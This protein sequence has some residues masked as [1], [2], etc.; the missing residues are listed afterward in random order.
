VVVL[1]LFLCLEFVHQLVVFPLT[2][3]AAEE[4]EIHRETLRLK[5]EIRLVGGSGS[6]PR[7]PPA[8][9]VL[10]MWLQ[11]QRR[12]PEFFVECSKMERQVITLEKRATT[13]KGVC[14]A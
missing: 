6:A 5:R 7:P 12:S 4:K 2:R 9:R 8:A 11:P 13:L 14:H 10:L 1:G 3:P